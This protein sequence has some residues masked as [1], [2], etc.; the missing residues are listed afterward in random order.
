MNEIGV[1]FYHPILYDR[2]AVVRCAAKT[3]MI[4]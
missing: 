3:K 4:N 1:Y 2:G